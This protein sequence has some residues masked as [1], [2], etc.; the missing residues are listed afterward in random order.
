MTAKRSMADAEQCL[1]A[2]FSKY[3]RSPERFAREVLDSHWWKGQSEVGS[4]LSRS[5]R[6]AVKAANGVG[7][8]YLAADLTLWFMSRR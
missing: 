2:D 1:P 7:K 3:K 4:L 8:T 6:V 5:R